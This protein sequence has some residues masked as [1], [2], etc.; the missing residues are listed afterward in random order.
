MKCN[1][2]VYLTFLLRYPCFL[3][4]LTLF[5][6]LLEKY[7]KITHKMCWHTYTR[8]PIGVAPSECLICCK[9]C[10]DKISLKLGMSTILARPHIHCFFVVLK[11]GIWLILKRSG[12]MQLCMYVYRGTVEYCFLLLSNWCC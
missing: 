3:V 7:L 2:S 5:F 6:I 12:L 10:S 1:C 4:M 8:S 9:M 11:Q